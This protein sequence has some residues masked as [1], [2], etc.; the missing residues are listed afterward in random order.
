MP[1]KSTKTTPVSGTKSQDTTV[2]CPTGV[3]ITKKYLDITSRV[4]TL[5][6]KRVGLWWNGKPN[7][8]VFLNRV[9][10]LLEKN[11]K[12]IKIIKFWEVDPERTALVTKYS[13]E[14]LDW[15]ANSVDIVIASSAD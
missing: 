1:G 12:S 8:D 3:T 2:F 6:G 9:A 14:I 11:Y 15:I 5:E 13:D 4:S 7:G 10:E